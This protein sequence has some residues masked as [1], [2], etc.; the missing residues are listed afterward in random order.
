MSNSLRT[1]LLVLGLT[2]VIPA[3]LAAGDAAKGEKLAATCAACHG[4]DGN[5]PAPSFP[6]IAGL[7]EKYIT[8]QLVDIKTKVRVVP[9]MTGLLD[10]SSEQDLADMAAFFAGKPLQLAGAK[11]LEVQMNSGGKIDA[12]VLGERLYRAGNIATKTPACTGCHSPKGLGNEPAAFPRLSGQ[13]AQY[14]EKQLRDF[15]GGN[16]VNDGEAQVMRKVAENLSDSEITALA[17][18]IAGLN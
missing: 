12:L 8:K 3:A 14:I 1:F 10:N 18:Y 15:R 6:K 16:R 4:A 11:K 13:Y 5:S 7:G 2:S 9:E 17:N